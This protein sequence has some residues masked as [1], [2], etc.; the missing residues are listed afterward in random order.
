MK[1][2]NIYYI[3]Y[4]FYIRKKRTFLAKFWRLRQ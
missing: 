1:I 2:S 4:I 3:W